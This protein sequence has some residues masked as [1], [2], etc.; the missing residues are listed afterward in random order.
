MGS[1]VISSQDNLHMYTSHGRVDADVRVISRV[2][3]WPS[4]RDCT[5]HIDGVYP[6]D[7]SSDGKHQL[8]PFLRGKKK[9]RGKKSAQ[10]YRFL[11]SRAE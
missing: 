4:L 9:K 8:L 6:L 11:R 1:G 10:E 5:Y 7:L 2:A 3:T